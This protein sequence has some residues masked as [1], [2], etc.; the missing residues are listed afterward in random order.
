MGK[1]EL[2]QATYPYICD[3]CGK[4]T[5]QDVCDNVKVCEYITMMGHWGYWSNKDREYHECIIC[6]ECYN[7]IRDFINKLGGKIRIYEYDMLNGEPLQ[8][9]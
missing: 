3:V 7:K 1:N 2:V 6:E 9:L 4:S 8:E 5:V